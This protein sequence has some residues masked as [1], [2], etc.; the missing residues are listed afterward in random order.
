MKRLLAFAAL[1]PVLFGAGC[2]APPAGS[3]V[4][5]EHPTIVSLNPCT[6]AILAEWTPPEQLLAI[7]HYSHAP[8]A[9]SMEAGVA[10]RYASTGGTVEEVL[11]LDPDVVVASTFIA[12]ATRAALTDL[13]YRVETFGSPRTIAE[14]IAQVERLG[15]VSGHE[16]AAGAL[17]DRLRAVEARVP[18]EGTTA[19]VWQPGGIVPGERSLV[20]ELLERAGFAD[21]G[22]AM[23]LGQADYLGLERVLADPPDVLFVAGSELGQRHP[24]LAKASGVRVEALDPNLLYCGGPTILRAMERLG[25]SRRRLGPRDGEAMSRDSGLR[26]SPEIGL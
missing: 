22:A 20:V 3:P 4:L 25:E 13:G 24:A 19:V 23:G 1:A 18:E 2:E 8:R 14:S 21:G 12:P 26:P 6:D 17:A 9:T 15:A 5:T 7:S 11:A 16:D 10:A